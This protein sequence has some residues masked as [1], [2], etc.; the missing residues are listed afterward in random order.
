MRFSAVQ[1]ESY[2][3]NRRCDHDGSEATPGQAGFW[4]L[5][6]N[7]IER[8]WRRHW[9]RIVCQVGQSDAWTLY[10]AQEEGVPAIV[11]LLISKVLNES[12]LRV[13][14]VLGLPYSTYRRRVETCKPLPEVAGY[15]VVA[16]IRLVAKLRQMLAESG[17]PVL[18]RDFD[19]EAWLFVWL[20]EPCHSLGG[21]SPVDLL[22]SFD[23]QRAI[24]GLLDR[25]LGGM[26]G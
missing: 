2:V 13:L 4:S 23:G 17:D 26:V 12:T 21:E 3:V 8:V 18:V 25:M 19:V 22:G 10:R 7:G 16:L 6:S 15:R 11:V 14:N 5:P 24:D 20:R 1:P 9:N